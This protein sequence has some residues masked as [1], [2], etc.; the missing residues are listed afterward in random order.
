MLS[1]WRGIAGVTA[2]V[3]AI[4]SEAAL[5]SYDLNQSSEL[6]DGRPYLRV[7]IDDQGAP[8]RI[9]FHVSVLG[10]LLEFADRHFGIDQFGFNSDF[11]LS[12]SRIVGLPKNWKYGGSETVDGFGRFDATVEAKSASARVQSLAFSITGI[13]MDEISSYLERSSGHARYGNFFFVAHVAGLDAPEFNCFDD[14]YFAGSKPASLL[15]TPLP[16][17]ARLLLAGLGAFVFLGFCRR[18]RSGCF[19]RGPLQGARVIGY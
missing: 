16:A 8:G 18:R 13:R 19:G 17:S 9:N 15:S 7:T 4:C 1:V 11:L 2:L 5:V 10:S 6:P 3:F 14:A 12:S